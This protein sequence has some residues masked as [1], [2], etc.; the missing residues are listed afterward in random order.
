MEKLDD[1]PDGDQKSSHSDSQYDD[2]EEE[3]KQE[4]DEDDGLLR[5]MIE[6]ANGE[7]FIGSLT[8]LEIIFTPIKALESAKLCHNLIQLSLIHTNTPSIEGI[9]SW[10]HSLE[11]L[12]LVGCPLEIMEPSLTYWT[13][14]RELSMVESNIPWIQN[15]ENWLHLEKLF[16]YSN[17]ISNI[18]GLTKSKHLKELHIQDNLISKVNGCEKLP[19][20][21]VLHLSGNRIKNL[22]DLKDIENLPQLQRLSFACENF[23]PCPVAEISGYRQYVLSVCAKSPYLQVLD[24]EYLTQD[25]VNYA[26]NEFIE[27]V[28]ELQKSLEDV[29]KSHRRSILTIDSKLKE[30]EQHLEEIED[31]LVEELN[32]LRQDIEDGKNKLLSE[33]EKLK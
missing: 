25:D 20:L 30:N 12:M 13:N 26:K 17:K 23:P 6:S 15:L 28:L 31:T 5:E 9:E 4:E 14:L 18:T 22:N 24:S 11:K 10:G 2:E 7:D 21:Q 16:L 1:L 29:E 3:I 33:F 19:N 8:Q 27:W 32:S